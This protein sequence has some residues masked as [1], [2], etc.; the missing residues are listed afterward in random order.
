[1]V[2]HLA[3]LTFGMQLT[4]AKGAFFQPNHFFESYDIFVKKSNI[5][6]YGTIPWF[7][8]DVLLGEMRKTHKAAPCH[9]VQ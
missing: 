5:A 1:M 8:T 3:I 4:V 6:L 2:A 7:G 9:Y